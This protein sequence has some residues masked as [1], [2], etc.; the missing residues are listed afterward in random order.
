MTDPVIHTPDA[1]RLTHSPW[2]AIQHVTQIVDGIWRIDTASHGGLKLS[3]QRLAAMPPAWR[4]MAYSGNGWF[5]EDCDWG[6]VALA[7]PEAFKPEHVAIARKTI[8]SCYPHL[9]LPTGA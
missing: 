5:E 2:G 9:T 1:R 6:L 4:S 8:A 3:D 7:F